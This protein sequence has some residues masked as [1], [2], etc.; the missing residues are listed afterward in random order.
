MRTLLALFLAIHG[1]I[2]AL[3]FVKAFRL[4]PVP[5]LREEIGRGT[6]LLWLAAGILLVAGAILLVT[7]PRVWWMPTLVGVVLSQAL[8]V[9]AWGDARFGTVANAIILLPLVVALA[10]LRPGSLRSRYLGD[11]RR[12]LVRVAPSPPT[13]TEA[14]LADLP[15]QVAAY[16]RRAGVVGRPRVRSFR[17][18]FRARMRG[19]PDQPWMSATAEQYEIFDPPARF[20]F[21]EATRA[22][23]PFDVY[24]RYVGDAATMQVRVFGLFPVV[25]E[26]GPVLTQSETV[27]LLNDMFFLAPASLV[28]A[29]IEWTVVDDRTV[30]ATYA[31]AGYTVSALAYFDES[32][33]LE[34][35][36][37]EDRWQIDGKERRLLPW[38]TPM[39]TYGRVG[40]VRL[41]VEAE[42]R[43]L[44]PDG[45]WAYGE[46]VIEGIEYNVGR[47]GGPHR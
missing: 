39:K 43:W 12:E 31:N 5:Q 38:T 20:F 25:D 18:E 33:D 32:G 34:D 45:A 40:D 11:V 36:R 30:R 2:H 47:E 42:A 10:D 7:A 15:P 14:D 9:G 16:L 22:G 13:L 3:G 44:D 26:G 27:T 17:A 29:P 23:V 46:F 37:S 35:F 28:D 41:A 1:A 19:G 6:G 8:I 4:A 21:M 24:H